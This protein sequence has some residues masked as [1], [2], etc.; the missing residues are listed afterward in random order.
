MIRE[1]ADDFNNMK[2]LSSKDHEKV[3]WKANFDLISIVMVYM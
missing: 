2:R 1:I 3:E